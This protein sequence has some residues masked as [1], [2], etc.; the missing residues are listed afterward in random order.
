MIYFSDLSQ[1]KFYGKN[2]Y[3]YEIRDLGD[4]NPPISQAFWSYNFSFLKKGDEVR[5]WTSKR[6]TIFHTDTEA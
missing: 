6:L 2:C 3:D 5:G 4:F 1:E